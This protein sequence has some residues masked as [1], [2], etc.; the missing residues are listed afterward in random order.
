[1]RAAPPEQEWIAR[2]RAGDR[3]AFDELVR[4]HFQAV[5]S[6]LLRIANQREDAEDLAQ[7]TFVRAHSSLADYRGDAR[8]STWLLRIAWHLAQD[9]QRRNARRGR[10]EALDSATESVDRAPA[11]PESSAQ[12]EIIEHIRAAVLEL[13][14]RLRAVL[15]LR[16]IEGREYDEIA[17][18]VGV[19]P[20]TARTQVVEARR[21]LARRLG[22]LLDGGVV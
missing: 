4:L 22:P 9:E 19:R 17:R 1:M 11:P 2:A 21:E 7:E 10:M 18:I 13:P 6:F 5:N 20:A 12:R 3:A 16:S 15:V 8:F 14:L